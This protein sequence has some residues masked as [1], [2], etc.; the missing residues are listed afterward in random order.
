MPPREVSSVAGRER[1]T[2][3]RAPWSASPRRDVRALSDDRAATRAPQPDDGTESARGASGRQTPGSRNRRCAA[4]ARLPSSRALQLVDLPNDEV[5]FDASQ[6]IDEDRAV[7]V[8]H[9]VLKGPR[10]EVLPL[11]GAFGAG[12][13]EAPNDSTRRPNDRRVEPRYAEAAFFFELHPV[14]FD[15]DGVDHDN[16]ILSVA[17]KRYIDDEYTPGHAD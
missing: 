2:G 13:I 3:P 14:A 4:Q 17:A 7:E 10:Q 9:F 6:S 5:L 8:V 12:S 11:D 15:E 1:H 16:Q